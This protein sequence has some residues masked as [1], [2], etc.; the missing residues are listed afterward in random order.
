M[1]NPIKGSTYIYPAATVC[2]CVCVSLQTFL[3]NFPKMLFT[4]R[5][6]LSTNKVWMTSNQEITTM[7]R[8]Y[9]HLYKAVRGSHY[10]TYRIRQRKN[11]MIFS[12]TA[13]QFMGTNDKKGKERR[14]RLSRWLVDLKSVMIPDRVTLTG[15]TTCLPLTLLPSEGTPSSH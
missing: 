7:G 10:L 14:G 12:L 13:V 3:M 11:R 4:R 9:L 5:C 8:V 1:C 6:Y 2:E 15:V